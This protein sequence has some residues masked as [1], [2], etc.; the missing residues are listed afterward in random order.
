MPSGRDR[1]RA[2]GSVQKGSKESGRAEMNPEVLHQLHFSFVPSRVLTMGLRF[3][4]FSHIASGKKTTEAVARAA[5][6]SERGTRMLLNS[7]AALGLLAKRQERYGLAPI[8]ARYLVRK[9]PDYLGSFLESDGMWDAWSHLEEAIRTGQP[10]RYVEKQE[11]AEEFFPML[12]RTLHVLQLDRAR[13]AAKAIA[14]GR[15]KKGGLRIVDVACGSGVWSIPYAEANPKTRVTAQDFPVVL[16]TT[17]SYLKRHGVASQYDYLPGNL[18]AVDFGVDRYDLALLGNIVHSEGERSARDLLR[19]L[20][21]ALVPGG[22]VVILDMVPNDDRTAPSFPV[23]FALNMLMNTEHGDT[24]TVA[25]YTRWLK[26]ASFG[27]VTTADIGAHSPLIVA[28][29]K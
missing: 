8:A 17:R 28:T 10:V 14:A 23:F 11:L 18:K 15:G 20:H 1:G 3:D 7:L 12:V 2:A 21:R 22:R 27:R 25:E 5:R 19:R 6:A 9:S 4:V 24:Y 13:M 16:K 26:D 29:K